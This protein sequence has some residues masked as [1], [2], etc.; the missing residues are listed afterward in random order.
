MYGTRD[1]ANNWEHA[2]TEFMVTSGFSVGNITPCLVWHKDTQ[3]VVDVHGNDFT[4]TGGE[5]DLEWSWTN[6][7]E[8]FEVKHTARLGPYE[9]DD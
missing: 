3:L 8:R 9:T 7:K 4:N 1:T 5:D 6:I 2:Y